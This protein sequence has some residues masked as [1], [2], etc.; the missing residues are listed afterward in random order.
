MH[1]SQAGLVVLEERTLFKRCIWLLRVLGGCQ[2]QLW[3]RRQAAQALIEF[4]ANVGRVEFNGA[5]AEDVEGEAAFQPLSQLAGPG[6]EE[7]RV[8]C[9][10]HVADV[11]QEDE[12]ARDSW[13]DGQ[14]RLMF[15]GLQH[16]LF[17]GGSDADRAR[18]HHHAGNVLL[19]EQGIERRGLLFLKESGMTHLD[20]QA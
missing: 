9:A 16:L 3:E 1:S 19:M 13:I 4:A 2:G 18:I 10:A 14:I 20:G 7:G 6:I 12:I 11:A 8:D 15:A 5:M 17:L